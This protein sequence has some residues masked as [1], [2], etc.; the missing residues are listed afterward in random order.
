MRTLRG[1]S[2][3]ATLL[4]VL[5][6]SGCGG[7]SSGGGSSAPTSTSSVPAPSP[8]TKIGIAS[9][10]PSPPAGTTSS[11]SKPTATSSGT[12][13]GAP[14]VPEAARQHTEAGAQAFAKYYIERV[15]ETA[16]HP[17]VGVLEPLALDTCKTCDNHEKTVRELVRDKQ[18]FSKPEMSITSTSIVGDSE[19]A[20]FVELHGHEP[21]V[22]IVDDTGQSV[23]S[24][25]EVKD[26]GLSFNLKWTPNGWR[27]VKLETTD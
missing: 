6:A 16:L 10:E 4:A 22:D 20:T 17:K 1:M 19:V 9:G 27:V 12:A 25:P 11:S 13:A 15:N 3:T 26:Q 7:G 24:F 23:Q 5:V 8:S 21:K 14:G 18:H 2:T